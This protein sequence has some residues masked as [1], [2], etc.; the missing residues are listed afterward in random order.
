MSTKGFISPNMALDCLSNKTDGHEKAT[1]GPIERERSI[2]CSTQDINSS[3]TA[4]TS[5][6][7]DSVPNPNLYT[8]WQF[9]VV[10]FVSTEAK[11]LEILLLT[12]RTAP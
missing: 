5:I 8:S 11:K 9:L 1:N 12:L 3:H 7:G 10:L 2:T 6:D 4:D